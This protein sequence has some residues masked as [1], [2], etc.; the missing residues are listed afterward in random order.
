MN[1]LYGYPCINSQIFVSEFYLTIFI[2]F[3]LENK[4]ICKR[5]IINFLRNV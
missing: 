2:K 3:N 4:I 5:N 1:I